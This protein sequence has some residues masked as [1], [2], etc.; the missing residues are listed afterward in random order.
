[1]RT[2]VERRTCAR[3]TG[4]SIDGFCNVRLRTGRA[5][6][7]VNASPEGV[8]VETDARLAPGSPLDV[9]MVKQDR[10]RTARARVVYARVCGLHPT[11]GARYRIGLRIENEARE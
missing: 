4:T 7:L 1:M 5:L 2:L 11:G 10:N 9:V 8:C 3:Q 6:T